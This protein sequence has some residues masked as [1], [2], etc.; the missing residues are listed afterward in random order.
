LVRLKKIRPNKRIRAYPVLSDDALKALDRHVG[1]GMIRAGRRGL[2][3]LMS[4]RA[5]TMFELVA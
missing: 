1:I 3:S 2:D 5:D 4:R